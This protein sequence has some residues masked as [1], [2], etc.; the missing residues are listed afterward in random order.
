MSRAMRRAICLALPLALAG[1]APA[2]SR[3]H[4][5]G[6]LDG[7]A[8]PAVP[9]AGR[10]AAHVDVLVATPRRAPIDD[11]MHPLGE[12]A[13]H[14][15]IG[16]GLAPAPPAPRPTAAAVALV[17]LGLTALLTGRIKRSAA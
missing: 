3:P 1:A 11:D 13:A 8:S 4:E 17:A 6:T 5:A 9:G 15:P 16:A 2:D 7:A 10:V 14:V 12:R